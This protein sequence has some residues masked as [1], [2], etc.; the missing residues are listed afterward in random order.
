MCE[1]IMNKSSNVSSHYINPSQGI[2][3]SRQEGLRYVIAAC[4]LP[5]QIIEKREPHCPEKYTAIENQQS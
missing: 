3:I 5:G 1:T 2:L 4:H